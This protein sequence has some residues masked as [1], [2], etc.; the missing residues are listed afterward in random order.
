MSRKRKDY[1][2]A[3]DLYNSGLSIGD[4]ANYYGVTRQSMW[5]V[6]KRRNVVMREQLK[7]GQDNHFW[8]GTS[9]D[10]RAQNMVEKAIKKGTL[11]APELC[12]ICGLPSKF[13]DGR[14]GIQ[15]HH[16]DYNKP[17]E[18]RWLCQKCHHDWHKTHKAIPVSKSS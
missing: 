17:L 12:S 9:D 8:R 2:Q 4:V 11:I 7:T 5:K 3:I 1:Q 18:V 13:K 15:A 14:N 10:D 16:D 6:F